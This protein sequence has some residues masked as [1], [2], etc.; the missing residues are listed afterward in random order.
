MSLTSA[1]LLADSSSK[2]LMSSGKL[3]KQNADLF[4]RFFRLNSFSRILV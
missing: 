3:M 2:M 4:S 1:L